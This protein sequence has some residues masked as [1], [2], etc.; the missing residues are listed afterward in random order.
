VRISRNG[1]FEKVCRHQR[2]VIPAEATYDLN[3]RR[4][5]AVIDEAA[6]KGRCCSPDGRRR[7]Y[8]QCLSLNFLL[9]QFDETSIAPDH[10]NS[11]PP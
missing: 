5:T 10:R 1:L 7:P 11:L 4:Q 9:P 3:T 2:L 8:L 6:P